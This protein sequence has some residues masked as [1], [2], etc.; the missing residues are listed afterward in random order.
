MLLHKVDSLLHKFDSLIFAQLPAVILKMTVTLVMTVRVV[1]LIVI[2]TV[3]VR[4][5]MIMMI[6]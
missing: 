1:I 2:L 5:Q 4:P 3:I 6:P